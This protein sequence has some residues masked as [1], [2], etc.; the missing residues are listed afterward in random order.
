[1]MAR[2]ADASDGL[3]APPRRVLGMLVRP[4]ATLTAAIAHGAWATVW[5]SGLLLWAA[6][7]TALLSTPVGQQALVD[8]RV[9]VVEAFGGEVDDAT[10]AAWQAQPPVLVYLTSG[11]RVWLLPP[12]T[13]AVA[14]GLLAAARRYGARVSYRQML[15]VV[16]HASVVLVLQQLLAAPLHYGRESLT[17][18]WNLAAL[19]PMVEEGTALALWLGSVDVFGLWWLWLLAV[20]LGL[21]TGRSSRGWFV[22]LVAAYFAIAALAALVVGLTGGS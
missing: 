17:G 21:V 3:P 22:R 6:A 15:A 7:A 4:A 20:G 2:S 8:E 13:L 9:R 14:A 5:L 18:A 11:G 10:Y 16:T 19:L 12:V 1:M